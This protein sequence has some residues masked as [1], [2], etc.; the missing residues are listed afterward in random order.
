M[1]AQNTFDKVNELK[2]DLLKLRTKSNNLLKSIMEDTEEN[3]LKYL[4]DFDI[5]CD[6]IGTATRAIKRLSLR[7]DL[8]Y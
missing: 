7:I 4:T 5:I 3:A 6:M 8:D 1:K 2:D